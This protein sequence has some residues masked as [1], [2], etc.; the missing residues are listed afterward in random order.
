MKNLLRL[1]ILIGLFI[2]VSVFVFLNPEFTFDFSTSRFIQD[3]N[4]NYFSKVMWFVTLM[5]NRPLMIYIIAITGSIL[6]LYGLRKEAVISTLI[7]AVG[8]LSGSL[9][10]ILVNRERPQPEFVN[11]SVFLSDK[12]YPSNHVLVFTIFFGFLLYLLLKKAKRNI[13]QMTLTI[14]LIIFLLTIGI[15]RIY[16]GAHWATDV[17]GGYILG[18]SWLVV[19]IRLY[20]FHNGKR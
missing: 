12:S 16:L 3:I 11:V 7:T 10:K 6:Y 18:L 19:A 17:A 2:I 1:R 8:A 13:F 5:G 14:V 15:S 20:N 9:I 4:Q